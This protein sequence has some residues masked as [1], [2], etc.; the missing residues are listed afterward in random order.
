MYSVGVCG[1]RGKCKS[2]CGGENTVQVCAV[3]GANIRCGGENTVQV[4]V[5]GGGN[6]HTA[7]AGIVRIKYRYTVSITLCAATVTTSDL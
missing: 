1:K 7:S 3:G 2:R 5:V 6:V 4:C